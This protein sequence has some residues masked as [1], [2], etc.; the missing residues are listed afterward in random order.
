MSHE[1]Q[2]FADASPGLLLAWASHGAGITNHDNQT[3]QVLAT[4]ALAKEQRTANI[5]ALLALPDGVVDPVARAE[6]IRQVTEAVRLDTDERI[7]PTDEN[8]A[9]TADMRLFVQQVTHRPGRT[10][11][12]YRSQLGW[13]AE[14][15]HRA[16]QMAHE[17]GLVI[18]RQTGADVLVQ[19]PVRS[20]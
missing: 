13:S 19:P 3:S 4:I 6:A 14:R 20:D 17:R 10:L 15:A 5:L 18:H 7:Y 1:P 8:P 9:A 11:T 12:T 16:D 2:P